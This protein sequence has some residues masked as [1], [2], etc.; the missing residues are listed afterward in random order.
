M[1]KIFL[2]LS[3]VCLTISM[4][5]YA[6]CESVITPSQAAALARNNDAGSY[7][8]EGY[9]VSTVDIYCKTSTYE[10]QSFMMADAAGGEAV[11][12][13]WRVV[14]VDHTIGIGSLVRIE[15]ATLQ[16]Y[17]DTPETKAGFTVQVLSE[18]PTAINLPEYGS[19]LEASEAAAL[20]MSFPYHDQPTEEMFT[21]EGYAVEVTTNNAEEGIQTVYLSDTKDGVSSFQAWECQ[22]VKNVLGDYML[23]A[24]GEYVFVTGNL[25]RYNRNSQIKGGIIATTAVDAFI[26]RVS[27]NPD[28]GYATISGKYEFTLLDMEEVEFTLSATAD[29]GYKFLMWIDPSGLDLSEPN[30]EMEEAQPILDI[31]NHTKDMTIDELHAYAE[32]ESIEFENLM[33]VLSMMDKMMQPTMVFD[34]DDLAFWT[35]I[36][37]MPE[38]THI[39]DFRAVFVAEGQGVESIQQSAVSSQKILR[40][41]QLLIVRDGKTFNLLGTEVR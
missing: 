18:V 12:E 13:A 22:A 4:Q 9:V 38:D 19:S 21:V 30:A 31:Y 34:I 24:K 20:C 23:I 5:V 29:P 11:F 27:A 14:G 25:S 10:N 1:K 2:L 37:E 8:I 33:A 32:E 6:S 3:A 39:F 26:A 16:V 36:N 15:N 28:R 7:C 41:G 17:N 35:K 40:D